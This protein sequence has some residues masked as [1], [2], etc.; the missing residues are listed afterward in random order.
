MQGIQH[1]IKKTGLLTV[2]LSFVA[3]LV[4][5]VVLSPPKKASAAQLTSRSLTLSSSSLGSVSTGAAGSGSNGLKAKHTFTAT[6][7]TSGSTIGSVSIMYC[8]NPIPV[9]GSCTSPTGL[10]LTHV[11]SVQ[12]QTG[13]T[14]SLSLDT[15]TT[16][17]TFNGT[18]SSTG[19]ASQGICNGTSG[20]TTRNNCLLLKMAS[21]QAQTGTATVTLAFGGGSSDYITNP[22]TTGT[23]F[24]RI[25][26]YSDVAYGTVVD[27]GS[28]ASSTTTEVTI[29]AKVQEALNFSVGTT[30]TAPSTSCTPFSDSGA[31]SIGDPNNGLSA[32]TSY[33]GHSYFRISTN[34]LHGTSVYYS[35]PTLT[36]GA[37]TIAAINGG[38][39]TAGG[40]SSSPGTAQFGLGIDTSDTQSG[41]GY[42]FSSLAAVSNPAYGSAAGTITSGGTAKFNFN[43]GSATTPIAIATTSNVIT[44]D[45][46]SVRYLANIATNTPPGIYSTT[47]NYIAVPSY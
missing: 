5:G 18:S 46:G 44:C 2:A 3:V 34:A 40:T 32:T 37:N 15:T 20:S 35:A 21:P 42:S 16:N 1:V 39:E 29:T 25:T 36:S 6:L 28:V 11:A 13:F 9:A 17:G 47:V 26:T 22:T 23:F 12:S 27:N 31:L 45:T 30:V 4:A 19:G 43:P 38:T 24:V 7:G 8:T 41:S 14:G 10:D 33:D